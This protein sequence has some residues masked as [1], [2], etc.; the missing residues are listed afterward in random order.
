MRTGLLRGFLV[1]VVL[2][3]SQSWV[4][5]ADD[6]EEIRGWRVY[7][8]QN[9]RVCCQSPR[10]PRDI[11]EECERLRRVL[12]EHWL[13]ANLDPW[14]EPCHVVFHARPGSYFQAVGR[15]GEQTLGCATVS[16]GDQGISLRRLDLRGDV[17][18][19]LRHTVPHELTHVVVAER[20]VEAD[21]PRWADEGLAVLADPPEKQSEYRRHLERALTSGSATRLSDLLGRDE[22]AFGNQRGLFYG[23]SA[24]LVSFLMAE[25]T[26]RQLLD[27]L[28][29]ANRLGY[30][31]SLRAHYRISDSAE[32]ERRWRRSLETGPTLSR[33]A[34]VHLTGA[35]YP[36]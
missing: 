17:P 24:S 14:P 11:A 35:V 28:V 21:P 13:G 32:L 4:P 25:G 30:T 6:W 34:G 18:D 5:A 10:R 33:I 27:F 19:P 22:L 12:C 1:L 16:Y 7:R 2:R 36:D 20:F 31:E 3:L 26:P 29:D 9:F 23:Q 15:G 8:S